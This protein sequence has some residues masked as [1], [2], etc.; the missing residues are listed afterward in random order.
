[1]FQFINHE[2]KRITLRT[3]FTVPIARIYSNAHTDEVRR[4]S[5]FG[6]VYRTQARHKGRSSEL[7]QGG[8]ELFGLPGREGDQECLSLIEETMQNIGLSDLKLELGSAK[9]YK[10]LMTL[11]MDRS[12]TDILKKKK[13]SDMKHLVEAHDFDEDLNKLLLILPSAF[14]NIKCLR[15]VKEI[16]K[17]EELLEAIEEMESLYEFSKHK[18]NIIFDLCMVP[19]RSYYTGIMMKGFSY[20]SAHPILQG[21]RYDHLFDHFYKNVPSIGFSYHLNNVLDAIGKE[22]EAND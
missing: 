12:L 8:I 10:R 18:E 21:G 9:F 4:Y 13:S 15:E 19:E 16:V 2:G 3:D 20:Y 17:D 7:F 14:G 1:M 22:N 5:Y 11:V 6:K